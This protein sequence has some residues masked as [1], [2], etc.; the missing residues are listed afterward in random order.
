MSLM[1]QYPLFWRGSPETVAIIEALGGETDTLRASLRDLLA[2]CNVGTA[3]WGLELWERQVGLDTDVSKSNADRRSRILSRLRGT[4]TVTVAM[5]QNVAESFSNGEVDVLEDPS[6]YH[7]DVKFV[8]TL[9]IPPNMA[10][11]TAAL[12]EIKPAH[13]T[14]AY[15]YVY[16]TY[17]ALAP[18]THGQLSAYS[19]A[20]LREGK[21]T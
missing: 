3:T 15:I 20:A 11:L 5:I 17:A 19:H 13:L 16:N 8:G 12:D 4:G 1:D 2:Q 21:I 14:Y 10:D 6:N 9:G 7:F 18:L